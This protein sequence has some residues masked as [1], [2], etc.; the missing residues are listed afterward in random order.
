M[1][2]RSRFREGI[3]KGIRWKSGT[4]PAAV[5]PSVCTEKLVMPDIIRVRTDCSVAFGAT[6]IRREG[7]TER[8]SQKTCHSQ[9][10]QR[11]SG[12]RFP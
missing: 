11:K 1:V 5:C 10:P 3:E 7:A 8:T 4:V 2:I 12:V 9:V 6:V